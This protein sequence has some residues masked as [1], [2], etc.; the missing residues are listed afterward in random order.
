M[1]EHHDGKL[2]A[3]TI[4]KITA[5]EKKITHETANVVAG[6]PTAMAQKHAGQEI[7][8]KVLKDIAEGEIKI[9]GDNC[10][11]AG[12]PTAIAQSELSKSRM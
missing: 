7:N 10:P 2:D 9:T 6:G 3:E 4:S 11:V 1:Q 5:A 12:G 8:G